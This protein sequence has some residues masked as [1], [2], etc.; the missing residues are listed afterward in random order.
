MYSLGLF[1]ILEDVLAA[2]Y[3]SLRNEDDDQCNRVEDSEHIL[4][5]IVSLKTRLDEVVEKMPN[6]LKESRSSFGTLAQSRRSFHIQA[7]TLSCRCVQVCTALRLKSTIWLIL[8]E[9]PLHSS[10]YPPTMAARR[11]PL[12]HPFIT[13]PNY[14]PRNPKPLHL[15]RPANHPHDLQLR[16]R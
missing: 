9:S 4:A 2:A 12:C 10:T 8:I 3:T 15:Y 13:R 16:A 6:H 7:Q 11:S 1:E 14:A 5:N